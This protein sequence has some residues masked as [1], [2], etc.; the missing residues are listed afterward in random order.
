MLDSVII[1]LRETL[2]ASL[3]VSFLFVYSNI[4]RVRKLWM[5]WSILIGSLISLLLAIKMSEISEWFDGAGQEI[6]FVIVLISLAIL[7]LISNL[8]II[9]S[10][11]K[12]IVHRW[13][14]L[15]YSLVIIIA[16]TM[17]GAEVIIYFESVF[18]NAERL[19]SNVL[20]GV[21][22]LG[23][24]ISVGAVNYY[25]LAQLK[26][27]SLTLCFVMLTL[28][29]AGMVSQAI[30]Y[31]MQAGLVEDSYPVWD[32]SFLIS[33]PSLLGQLLYALIGYEA[34]PTHNQVVFYSLFI[35]VPFCYLTYYKVKFH[36]EKN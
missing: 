14:M 4:V 27:L 3:L 20:G 18:M 28:V 24:G 29:S 32:T 6:L 33:E 2:E 1:V 10:T 30:S 21:L 35:V 34:T 5:I 22:G 7:I 31:L 12:A 26:Q 13:H 25:F 15:L 8:L 36:N 16:M 19:S 11:K 23:V 9:S 17:E